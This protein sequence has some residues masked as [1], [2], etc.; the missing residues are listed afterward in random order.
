MADVTDYGS[1]NIGVSATPPSQSSFGVSMLM[2]DTE[3][4]AIDKRYRITTKGS[5]ATD[6]TA[7]S[8]AAG[9]CTTLWGQNYNPA[10]A[11]IGR[12]VSAASSP[13]IVFPSANSTITDWQAVAALGSLKI[14]DGTNDDEMLTMDFTTVTDLDDVCA[15]IQAAMQAIAAPNITGLD[16]ATCEVDVYGRIIIKN[17]TTGAAAAG[18]S[19]T[20]SAGTDI[21]VS[22]LLGAGEFSQDGLDV[23]S[24]ATAANAVL[25]LDNTPFVLCERGG[26]IAQKIAF[27]TTTNA[28]SKITLLNIFDTDAKDGSATTDV[29]YALNAL[30]LQKVHVAYTEWDTHYPDASLGGEVFPQTEGT[31]NLAL[32]PLSAVSESGKGA[33]GTTV[34]PLTAGERAALKAKGYDFLVR[35]A[36]L[37]HFDNGLAAGGYEI[38]VMF[39]KMFTEAKTSEDIYGY[40]IANKVVTFSDEDIAAIKSIVIVRLDQMVERKVLEAG[41]EITMPLASSFTATEKATHVMT[42]A[43]ISDDETQRAVNSIQVSLNWLV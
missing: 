33:D 26:S 25:A 8:V 15:V 4:V 30:G 39:A 12:W 32:T 2:V 29:G 38:R 14:T 10:T 28:L 36:T 27:A 13:Y 17:S 22:T 18:I 7:D 40:L 16:T 35:P 20:T 24:I 21:A 9:W 6:L 42:L 23:E 3:D 43:D 31:V 37:T 34:L 11:Y 41:Y 19:T 5:Y 1:L